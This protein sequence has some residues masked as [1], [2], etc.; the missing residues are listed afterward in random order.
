MSDFTEANLP[1]S[2]IYSASWENISNQVLEVE[3]A[4]VPPGHVWNQLLSQRYLIGDDFT[5]RGYTTQKLIDLGYIGQSW[6]TP[7]IPPAYLH[8]Q[9]Y[10]STQWFEIDAIEVNLNINNPDQTDE[11][12]FASTAVP[13]APAG[14]IINFDIVVPAAIWFILGLDTNNSVGLQIYTATS[15]ATFLYEKR[16]NGNFPSITVPLSVPNS[17]HIV[18]LDSSNNFYALN[19]NDTGQLLWTVMVS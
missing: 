2:V 16:P 18:F 19:V 17:Q 5:A 11:V 9:S 15:D 13:R 7:I 1:L 6:Y 12:A 10:E 8:L 14:S 3:K 4:L